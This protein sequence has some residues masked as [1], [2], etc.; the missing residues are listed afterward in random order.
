MGAL[1][2][3]RFALGAVQG[4]RLR[5]SLSA[6]GVAIGVAAV[7]LLTS[8]GEGTRQYIVGQFTQFGTNLLEINP[9][10]IKTM[11]M[12][13]VFG[14]TTH[15][16]TLDDAEAVRRVNGVTAMVPVVVGQARVEAGN[17]G[18]SVYVYG[19]GHEMQQ[20]WQVGVAQGS[21]LPAMDPHRQGAFAA[22]GPK[23]AKEIFGSESPLG[24]RVRI[25]NLSLLVIGV[26]EP[27]GQ[28]LGLDM[29]DSAYLPVATAMNLFN[30]SEL[31]A[32]DVLA[33]SAD[34]ILPV[35]AEIRVLL[36][37]R[38]R[39]EEDFTI[40]TQG[41]MLDTFGRVIGIITI[42]VTAIASVSLLVGAIGILT[43]MWISVHER[44][45][46]V[47]LLRALGVSRG[48]IGRLFLLEATVLAVIGGAGGLL[49]ATGVAAVIHAVAPGLPLRTPPLAV[50]VAV[51]VSVVV[52]MAS[53]YLP[54][55]R[56]AALD[57]V[58]ALRAE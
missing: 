10:K 16:L 45:G 26:M 20:V 47:G 19:V 17:R 43:V 21:F 54:A 57:P 27:K 32:I 56:A 31:M 13:G 51:A 44:T 24:R 8:L 6:L 2:L 1:E 30:Q 53:G 9:G 58:E 41:E 28:L 38:H 22:L 52:G 7:V 40:T 42:A 5:S 14:G 11:G 23:L 36:S 37:A 4:Q 25:G 33:A 34:R 48:G 12:P 18:R 50:P 49:L 29:D 35:V 46:E 15:K 3:L 55:R 39:G